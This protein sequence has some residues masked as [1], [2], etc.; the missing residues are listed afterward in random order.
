MN[1]H[2]TY[3]S[4][5]STNSFSSLIYDY[6]DEKESLKKFYEHE[7]TIEGVKA[8]IV[9][10]KEFSTN[11][12]L[13]HDV[14]IEAYQNAQ[15]TSNQSNNISSLKQ[16]NTFTICTAHQPN[17]FTG[18]LYFI[19]KTAHV[20]AI[21]RKLKAEMPEYNFVPVF[22]IGS[23]DND[24]DEL[25]KFKLNGKAFQWKSDQKGAVGR[26]K[27]DKNLL[28]LLEEVNKEVIHLP[29]GPAL[30]E[31]LRKAYTKGQDIAGATFSI[32]NDL[33]AEEGLL[34]LQPDNLSLKKGIVQIMKDD[35]LSQSAE[36]IVTR[37]SK[38]MGENYKLQVNPRSVNLFYL[39]DGI[40][41]RIEKRGNI[42]TVDDTVIKFTEAEIV[43]E[44]EEN[45]DRFSPNVILRGLYQETILPNILFVG[46]GSEVAYWMQL[47]DLFT[48]YRVPFPVLILR[49]SF[50]L[51]DKLQEHKLNELKLSIVD[52]FKE[53]VQLSNEYVQLLAGKE[54]NLKT[55]EEEGKK[56]FIHLK[57]V[58]GNID[59]TLVQHV[60]ALETD[61]FKKLSIL[62][63]KMLKAERNKQAVQL[64]RIWKLKSELFPSNT[65]QERVENF[66]PYY[67]QYGP[68]FI[69]SILGHSLS[70]D[71][72]FGV[73]GLV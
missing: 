67:A 54:I 9:T 11:R 55:E 28:S 12:A 60:H 5:Q 36:K 49:N 2:C 41:N 37:T 35:L 64:Q 21:A 51:M 29:F 1:S 38:S 68:E 72:Q 3:I 24:F 20:I 14:F 47:K 33:F 30:M 26:M 59:K 50:I 34:V 7:P 57:S 27:V 42:Y 13:I 70:L 16:E 23:E 65:L 69:K 53:E 71:Q 39:R 6:L 15:L 4:Y 32:L 73:I 52:L 63:K 10:R 56:Y 17:I 62:E 44:L 66:M 43:Q 45:P 19:Y 58:A 25:S 48:H 22:Y 31:M 8:A 18:Y 40:R 61:H 46:G